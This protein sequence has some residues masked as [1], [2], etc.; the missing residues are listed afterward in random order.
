[1]DVAILLRVVPALG[2]AVLVGW[3]AV[4]DRGVEL[5]TVVDAVLRATIVG[6]VAARLGWVLL[7]GPTVWRSLA[8]TLFLLRSGVETSLGA[9]VAIPWIWRRSEPD[10]RAWQ[11]LAAPAAVLAGIA[12]WQGLCGVEGVC[13]GAPASWGIRM[14][15]YASRV[16]PS[17]Y[18]EAGVAAVLAL[19]A[20]RWRAT[21][22]RA[23]AA[24]AVYVLARVAI[25]F[26]RA[27]LGALPTRDQLF[28]A[29][30]AVALGAVAW[31]QRR[32]ATPATP[33]ASDAGDGAVAP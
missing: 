12:V 17:G 8:S 30:L 28:A 5:G 23:T 24:A 32:A 20:F 2:A 13:A 1:M 18:I 10:E 19:A 6:L 27:S 31:R 11:L 33:R 21:P 16:A 15:G 7:G 9:L 3:L 14:G 4:R 26:T 22:W 29:I 25:G